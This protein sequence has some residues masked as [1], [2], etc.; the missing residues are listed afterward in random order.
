LQAAPG[1]ISEGEVVH[2]DPNTSANAPTSPAFR[3]EEF[4]VEIDGHPYTTQV[5][6]GV[7]NG[8]VIEVRA[9]F[10]G[11][12]NHI[13]I[14][15]GGGVKDAVNAAGDRLMGAMGMLRALGSMSKHS[16]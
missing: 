15:A 11:T 9:T 14:P 7:V 2:V 10:L 5:F 6:V 12:T 4:A 3:S 8:W 13:E 1:A 16:P